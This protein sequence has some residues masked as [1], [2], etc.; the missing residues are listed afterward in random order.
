MVVPEGVTKRWPLALVAGAMFFSGASALTY[1]IL[2]QRQMFLIFG[3]SAPAT[4]AIL[5]AI[6]LGIAIGSRLAGAWLARSTDPVR[7]YAVL[8]A[9]M[10]GWGFLV[11]YLLRL[12]DGVYVSATHALGEGHVLLSPIRFLL[13]IIPLLP[14]TLAMGATI[15]VMVRCVSR[16]GHSAVAWA[17]G[18]N[19]LG[20]VAG[21][22]LTGLVWIRWFGLLQTRLTAVGLNLA[23]MILLGIARRIEQRSERG[24]Q[25]EIESVRLDRQSLTSQS[26]GPRGYVA[27]Y[28]FAGFVALGMEVL[29]LRYLGIVNSNSSA[30]FTLTLTTYLL[31]MSFGSLVIYPFM[32]RWLSPA[33]IFSTAHGATAFSALATF[34]TIYAAALINHEQIRVPAL[35]GTL[36]LNDIYWTE[37]R[38]IFQLM[39]LPTIFM[40]LVY[41]A[42]CDTVATESPDRDAWISRSYFWGTLGSVAGILLVGIGLVPWLDLHGT[43]A[44][45]VSISTGLCYASVRLANPVPPTETNAPRRALINLVAAAG[46][47]GLFLWAAS[48]TVNPQPVLRNSLARQKDGRWFEVTVVR[49]HRNLSELLRV[50]AGP[51][52]TVMIKRELDQDVQLVYVDDQLVASTNLAAKVD[53]LMLAHLPL[54]LH[55]DPTSGLTVGFG[56]GG[57]SQSMTLHGIQ[58]YCAEIE[59]EVIRSYHLIR[60]DGFDVTAAPNFTLIL[61]DARDHL[62]AGSVTYDVIATDVTNLQYKQNGNLYTVEYFRLMQNKLNTDGIAC[63]WI[64]LAAID[65][66]ELRILMQSFREVFP[67]ATLWFMNHTHTNFGILIGTPE[68]LKIDFQRFQSGFSDPAL[69]ADLQ[70]IGMIDPMQLVHSLHLDEVGYAKFCGDAT[71]HTDDLPVLEFSSPLS[72]YHYDETFY[73]NLAQTLELRPLDFRRYVVNVPADSDARFAKHELASRCFCEVLLRYYEYRIARQRNQNNEAIEAWKQAM[74]LAT[75]GLDAWPEDTVRDQFYVS[76]LEPAM[77]WVQSQL[78]Q[79]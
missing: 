49:P 42:I 33:A 20:A 73:D 71:T 22:L 15:P 48:L 12:S 50:K 61:N 66:T 45:L 4:T 24:E 65:T 63:A 60:G 69:A 47:L 9:V 54:L 77:Q 37:A 28:F 53:S 10:G 39:F 38:I 74:S 62:H 44:L 56:T 31:G 64:P 17:Y 30:T 59:P 29:W 1:E 36:T 55:P 40:G 32:R 21:C 6:F 7:L 58:T 23:A 46:C 18:L 19:I 14:A 70:G 11:P 51:S 16:P 72:F 34:G 75:Q 67:H 79:R 52:A 27:M 43:F 57:T 26:V 25:N 5:T 78:G 35:A 41:P 8:E 2:W 3:A 13:A 68:P 76:F